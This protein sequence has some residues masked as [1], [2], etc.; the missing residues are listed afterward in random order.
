MWVNLKRSDVHNTWKLISCWYYGL[1]PEL[2]LS[3]LTIV[4][5]SALE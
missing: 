2:S 4:G 5:G 1:T 3:P